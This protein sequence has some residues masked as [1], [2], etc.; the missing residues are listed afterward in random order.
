MKSQFLVV[1]FLLFVDDSSP[2]R[3]LFVKKRL[4][5]PDQPLL[6]GR[7]RGVQPK[8]PWDLWYDHVELVGGLEHVL[9]SIIGIILDIILPIDF[10]IFQDG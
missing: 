7:L 1:K 5:G 9:F 2:T 4:Q 6:V 3:R 10:H 8:R